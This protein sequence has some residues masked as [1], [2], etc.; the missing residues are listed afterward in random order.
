MYILLIILFLWTWLC[1]KVETRRDLRFHYF[2]LYF[3][4]QNFQNGYIWISLFSIFFKVICGKWIILKSF[5]VS[6]NFLFTNKQV[7][8]NNLTFC[9]WG[10]FFGVHTGQPVWNS[11]WISP[12]CYLYIL[13]DVCFYFTKNKFYC[14]YSYNSVN[15]PESPGILSKVL[16]KSWNFDAKNPGN[17]EEKSWNLKQFFWGRTMQNMSADCPWI[18]QSC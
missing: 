9:F 12:C 4:Y 10:H 16:E 15:V 18:C 1:N 14:C 3:V 11:L 6:L 7:N 5:C 17:S 8:P 2:W 13:Q